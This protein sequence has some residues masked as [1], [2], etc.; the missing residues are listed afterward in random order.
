MLDFPAQFFVRFFHNH[1]LLS[2]NNRPQWRTLV[3]GSQAYLEPIT[4]NFRHAIRTGCRIK[5]IARS[6][7]NVQIVWADGTQETFDQV[8]LATHSDQALS[9]LS[10]A[11]VDEQAILAAI[12][13]QSNDVILHTD[14]CQLPRRRLAWAS[15]N[16][17]LLTPKMGV[18]HEKPVLT[19]NMNILQGLQSQHT[20][21]VTLNN[22]QA[23]DPEKILGT[24]Q[25]DHPVFTPEGT[26]AQQR[27][28]EINGINRTWFCGAYWANGFHEDGVVSGIRVATALGAQWP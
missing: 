7:D 1:G 5:S 14:I 15:W 26:A 3:G 11:S 13:Y 12:P 22:T 10:D 25:Y 6:I 23:I 27:W 8:I 2:V 28:S 20:L 18:S 21:C 9:L 19:Y 4:R 24:Y 16:T 17:K